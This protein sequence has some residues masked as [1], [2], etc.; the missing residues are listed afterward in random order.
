MNGVLQAQRI[1]HENQLVDES[2]AIEGQEGRDSF[3]CAHTVG[4]WLELE[5][6]VGENITTAKRHGQ[7]L[8]TKTTQTKEGMDLPLESQ[9]DDGLNERDD[10][11]R[12]RPE[13]IW[14][15][16]L[17]MAFTRRDVN[18]AFSRSKAAS[19]FPPKRRIK[20]ASEEGSP[21]IVRINLGDRLRDG[22][23]VRQRICLGIQYGGFTT[24]R[25]CVTGGWFGVLVGSKKGRE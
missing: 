10:G 23:C 24:G 4:F 15:V 8:S 3:G 18:I 12:P 13:R 20:R 14:N 5:L 1:V 9:S 22:A 25:R 21:R 19:S 11:K 2:E 16:H 17:A 7:Q 6:K